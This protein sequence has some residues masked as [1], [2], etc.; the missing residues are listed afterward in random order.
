MSE[1]MSLAKVKAHLSEVVDR[2]SASH[3]RVEITRH[4]HREAVL[5]AAD[6]LD[7]LEDTLDILSN[8]AAVREIAEARESAARGD[9][10]DAA[11]IR[12]HYLG[13]SA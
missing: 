13:R 10:L 1:T 4:G 6:D 12:Q 2:V 11:A 9:G 3:E 7:A 8:P 5:I